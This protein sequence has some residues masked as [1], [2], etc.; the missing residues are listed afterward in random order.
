MSV[1]NKMVPIFSNF[2][3]LRIDINFL[4]NAWKFNRGVTWRSELKWDVLNNIQG[5]TMLWVVF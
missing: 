4:N 1:Q 3:F 5:V 2:F